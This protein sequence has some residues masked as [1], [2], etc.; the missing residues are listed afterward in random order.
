MTFAGVNNLFSY[1]NNN[2]VMRVDPS[3]RL[4]VN[5]LDYINMIL[6]KLMASGVKFVRRFA[7]NYRLSIRLYL[8]SLINAKFTKYVV[9]NEYPSIIKDMTDRLKA[10]SIVRDRI[11]EYVK[12]AKNGSYEKTEP[13]RF[14]KPRSFGDKDLRLSIGRVDNFRLKVQYVGISKRMKKYKVTITIIDYY[15]FDE[16]K[17]GDASEMIRIINNYGGYY[18]MMLGLVSTY[19]W[20][21]VS[22]FDYYGNL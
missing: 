17:E 6:K 2:P 14:T 1:C 4:V 7:I 13:I 10:S 21:S 5:S 3:G 22:K 18:P 11:K 9:L 19:W 16:F 20:A 8:F 15:D 12:K